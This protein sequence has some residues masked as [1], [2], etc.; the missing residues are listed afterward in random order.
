MSKAINSFIDKKLQ[1]ENLN[2]QY[3]SG[4]LAALLNIKTFCSD[5]IEKDLIEYTQKQIESLGNVEGPFVEGSISTYSMIQKYAI[6]LRNHH[7]SPVVAIDFD[8][9]LASDESYPLPGNEVPHA[10]E[11]LKW[12]QN[13][14]CRLILYTMRTG[15]I[16]ESA[17]KFCSEHGI[18]FFGINSNPDQV[19]YPYAGNASKVYFDVLIDDHAL[20]IPLT[21]DKLVD[22]IAVK[23]LLCEKFGFD[24]P[25]KKHAINE[26]YGVLTV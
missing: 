21:Q 24:K 12:L 15:A 4:S 10:F 11:V 22:W 23:K 16:L 2:N 5:M 19:L 6:Y 13:K 3:S 7:E 1:E 26:K 8:N 20:G 18:E 25:E 17:V 9:T 14:G